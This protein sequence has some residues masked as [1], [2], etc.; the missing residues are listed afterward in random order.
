[1][2]DKISKMNEGSIND[3][4]FVTACKNNNIKL[5]KQLCQL[6]PRY[7]MA[8]KKGKIVKCNIIKLKCKFSKKEN[9]YHECYICYSK[10][11]IKTSCGH[12][13]CEDCFIRWG[14]KKCPICRQE[15]NYYINLI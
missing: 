6:N 2:K 9:N 15:V 1:M 4:I 5:A 12:Y 10:S 14:R 3:N 7:E 11:N 8:I 13:G